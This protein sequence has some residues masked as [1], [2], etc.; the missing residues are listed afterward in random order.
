MRTE[1]TDENIEP[2]SENSNDNIG[3]H[4]LINLKSGTRRGSKLSPVASGAFSEMGLGLLDSD[5]SNPSTVASD[6]HS[7]PKSILSE[8]SSEPMSNLMPTSN[9]S[10]IESDSNTD[11]ENVADTNSPTSEIISDESQASAEKTLVAGH[12]FSIHQDYT[13][14]NLIPISRTN[15]AGIAHSS[16]TTSEL[17]QSGRAIRNTSLKKH[18]GRSPLAIVSNNANV[19]VCRGNCTNLGSDAD[20]AKASVQ[21]GNDEDSFFMYRRHDPRAYTGEDN[22]TRLSDEVILSIFKWLPKKA[23]M[24]CSLVNHRFNRVSQ[25]ESLWT[26]LDLAMKTIQPYAFGRILLRGVVILRMAQCKVS[27]RATRSD[28]QICNQ[29]RLFNC[30]FRDRFSNRAKFRGNF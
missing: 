8:L 16:A 15:F 25:D 14:A 21:G 24:R 26:R 20:G 2:E 4:K 30:R 29:F 11:G 3:T 28:P 19:N 12:P 7:V 22:F 5:E 13:P 6:A 10:C 17:P 27:R 18:K 1:E 23:L 9:F